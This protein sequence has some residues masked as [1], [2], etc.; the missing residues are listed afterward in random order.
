MGRMMAKLDSEI[1]QTLIFFGL[2]DA[3]HEVFSTLLQALATFDV[4]LQSAAETVGKDI[5]T[6]SARKMSDGQTLEAA[7][8]SRSSQPVKNGQLDATLHTM[9]TMRGASMRQGKESRRLNRIMWDG[10]SAHTRM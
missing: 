1:R 9:R 4:Q 2:P 10:G 6:G 7:A 8:T 5:L 3:D